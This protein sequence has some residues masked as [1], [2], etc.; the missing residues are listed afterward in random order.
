MKLQNEWIIK[1][2]EGLKHLSFTELEEKL[3]DLILK[4]YEQQEVKK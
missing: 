2:L 3:D 4:L 1:E